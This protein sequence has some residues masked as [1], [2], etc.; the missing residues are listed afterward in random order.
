MAD[1]RSSEESEEPDPSHSSNNSGD[2]D[3]FFTDNYPLMGFGGDVDSDTSLH[4]PREFIFDREPSRWYQEES[5]DIHLYETKTPGL[6]KH[7]AMSPLEL[8]ENK[9]AL[10]VMSSFWMMHDFPA[11][12]DPLRFSCQGI[13]QNL[14]AGF[15]LNIAARLCLLLMQLPRKE[16]IDV[17]YWIIVRYEHDRQMV[18]SAKYTL[19]CLHKAGVLKKPLSRFN[20]KYGKF[21]YK[22]RR[23]FYAK[24]CGTMSDLPDDDRSVGGPSVPPIAASSIPMDDGNHDDGYTNSVGSMGPNSATMDYDDDAESDSDSSTLSYNYPGRVSVG[25]GRFQKP[26]R[27]YRDL[28]GKEDK[29]DDAYDAYKSTT[30]NLSHMYA[31]SPLELMEDKVAFYVMSWWQSKPASIEPRMRFS[32]EGKIYEIDDPSRGVFENLPPGFDL[33]IAARICLLLMQLPRTQQYLDVAYWIVDRYQH[34]RQMVKSAKYT[35]QCLQDAVII[36]KPRLRKNRPGKYLYKLEEKFYHEGFGT[37]PDLPGANKP[38][39][40]LGSPSCP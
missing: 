11:A 26:S 34:D 40:S 6:S 27:W 32:C 29:E 22:L 35:L 5:C 1:D 30:P 20:D 39:A 37:M 31:F 33:N 7:Y 25:K 36:Q 10:A 23:E 4:T 28:P 12:T 21:V 38:G 2:D 18:G 8:M 17:A 24:G 9:V 15:D 14:P 13:Y 3:S 16:Y 19:I